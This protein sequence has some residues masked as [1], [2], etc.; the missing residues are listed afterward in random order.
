MIYTEWNEMKLKNCEEKTIRW[1]DDYI[2][3]MLMLMLL[4]LLSYFPLI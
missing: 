3:L 4:R 2:V 1:L